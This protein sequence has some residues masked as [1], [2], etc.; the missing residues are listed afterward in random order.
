MHYVASLWIF[1]HLQLK[2]TFLK[3]KLTWSNEWRS[4]V[5]LCEL[6][7]QKIKKLVAHPMQNRLICFLHRLLTHLPSKTIEKENVCF[8]VRYKNTKHCMRD[9]IAQPSHLVVGAS[10]LFDSYSL[11]TCLTFIN[12]QTWSVAFSQLPLSLSIRPFWTINVIWISFACSPF[13]VG[14]IGGPGPRF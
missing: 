13:N 3:R 11:T 9:G 1:Y 12:C 6:W 5:L 7:K 4:N 10:I 14:G 2:D 8:T